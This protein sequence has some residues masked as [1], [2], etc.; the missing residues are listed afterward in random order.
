MLLL[1]KG[2]RSTLC[3]VP[4]SAATMSRSLLRGPSARILTPLHM[5]GTLGQFQGYTAAQLTGLASNALAES[6]QHSGL[7]A[8]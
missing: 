5:F 4:L 2:M 7:L 1:H 6:L 3:Y 8:L